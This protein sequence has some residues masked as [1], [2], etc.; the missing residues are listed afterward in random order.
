[1]YKA[2]LVTKHK[3]DLHGSKWKAKDEHSTLDNLANSLHPPFPW[4]MGLLLAISTV[5]N[6]FESSETSH[7]TRPSP[8]ALSPRTASP[9]AQSSESSANQ[10]LAPSHC[11]SLQGCHLPSI[12][13]V[14]TCTVSLLLPDWSLLVLQESL[15]VVS[16]TLILLARALLFLLLCTPLC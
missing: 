14:L 13:S 10:S 5:H 2:Q 4:R 11:Y 9:S 6:S 3:N 1:M 12:N 8:S 7:D 15:S 16:A